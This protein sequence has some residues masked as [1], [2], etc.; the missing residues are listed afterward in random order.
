MKN[1]YLQII[2]GGFVSF[3]SY[4]VGGFDSNFI[5]L[6][7]FIVI[8]FISGLIK[9]YHNKTL[10]SKHLISG[11]FKKTCYLFVV[12]I[13]VRLDI[14]CGTDEL[15]RTPVIY[16]L[17]AGEGLSILENMRD[18]GVPIPKIITDKLLELKG[19]EENEKGTN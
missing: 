5:T 12:M 17:I 14:T 2:I 6:M 8:D 7:I 19:G 4:M 1:Y 9:G 13:S 18:I 15:F 16:M 10:S 3:I 11:V